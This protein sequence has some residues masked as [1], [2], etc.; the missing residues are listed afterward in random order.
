MSS[1]SAA[2]VSVGDGVVFGGKVVVPAIWV[3]SEVGFYVVREVAE[4]GCFDV[5]GKAVTD[6]EVVRRVFVCSDCV[7]DDAI[8]LHPS[9]L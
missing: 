1:V 6:V 9:L 4:V 2:K 8:A 5:V 3:F 7:V